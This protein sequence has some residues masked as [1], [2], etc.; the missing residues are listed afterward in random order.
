MLNDTKGRGRRE[1]RR[2][3]EAGGE[4]GREGEDL[5]IC[6]GVC[7]QKVTN[8]GWS[9]IPLSSCFGGD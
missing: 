9:I 1:E 2:E 5:L 8:Y 4:R 7:M 6:H 3:R